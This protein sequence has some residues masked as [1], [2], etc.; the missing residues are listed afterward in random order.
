MTTYL[1]LLPSAPSEVVRQRC[2]VNTTTNLVPGRVGSDEGR[3]ERQQE[4]REAKREERGNKR[5]ERQSTT[6]EGWHD[7]KGAAQQER[8]SMTK[9]AEVHL[10]RGGAPFYYITTNLGRLHSWQSEGVDFL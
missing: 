7:V 3:Q 5:G 4:R 10:A 8:D 6:R 2:I 1:F 9:E